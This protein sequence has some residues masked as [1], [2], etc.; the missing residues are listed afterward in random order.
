MAHRSLPYALAASLVF[1]F[2]GCSGGGCGGGPLTPIPG[3]FPL[4][5]RTENGASV[6]VTE[7]GLTFF[8][9]NAGALIGASSGD[10]PVFVCVPESTS[11]VSV[12]G[13]GVCDMIVCPGGPD[14][15]AN[16]PRC[17]VELDAK[18]AKLAL[19]S[20]APDRLLLHGDSNAPGGGLPLRIQ[21]LPIAYSCVGGL[22]EGEISVVANGNDPPACPGEPQ[23]FTPIDFAAEMSIGIQSGPGAAGYSQITIQQISLDKPSVEQA[24]VLDCGGGADDAIAQAVKGLLVG[25]LLG[26][27]EATVQDQIVSALALKPNPDV[28]PP[29]PPGSMPGDACCQYPSG[30]CVTRPLG[31]EGR[32]PLSSLLPAAPSSPE[33]NMGLDILLLA[34]G[35]GQNPATGAPWGQLD[36]ALGGATLGLYGG[37]L[38]QPNSACVEPVDIAP[39]TGIPIPDALFQNTAPDWP[40]GADGPHLGLALSEAFLD[41]ALTAVHNSGLLCLDVTAESLPDAALFLNTGALKLL[42]PAEGLSH[43][44]LQDEPASVAITLRPGAPAHAEIGQGGESDPLLALSLPALSIDLYAFSLDRYV[45]F[46][47]L[48][49]DVAIGVDLLSGPEGLTPALR[50]FALDNGNVS[51]LVWLRPGDVNA[52]SIAAGLV[53]LLQGPIESALAGVKLNLSALLSGLGISVIVPQ[54]GI[55]KVSQGEHDYLA[56]FASFE[57]V[58]P[59]PSGG[60]CAVAGAAPGGAPFD[61]PGRSAALWLGVLG[62]GLWLRRGG[63]RARSLAMVS[64][65]AVA[66]AGAGC[67]CGS[68]RETVTTT[69]TGPCATCEELT[70][71]LVGAYSSAVS[72]GSTLWVAGYLEKTITPDDNFYSWGDLVVGRHDGSS[73]TWEIVDGLPAGE[74]VD[75]SRHDPAGFRGGRVEP[76]DDVGTFTSIAE[77]PAGAPVIAYHDRTHRSL[78]VAR[79]V[80]EEWLV[81]TVDSPSGGEAGR[82]ARLLSS[83]GVL[84]IAYLFVEPGEDGK[85]RSGVRLATTTSAEP[86]AGDWAFEEVVSTPV[87]PPMNAPAGYPAVTG[88]HIAI[89]LAPGETRP[90]IVYRDGVRGN[91]VSAARKDPDPAW[92]ITVL[93]GEDAAGDDTG[94]VG[95]G[96]SLFVAGDTWHIA[97][98]SASDKS[99]RYLRVEGGAVLPPEV[100]DIGTRTAT[101]TFTGR[102]AVGA[103]TSIFVAQDGVVHIAYQDATSGT[104][105]HAAAK[106]GAGWAIT[107]LEQPGFGGFFPSLLPHDGALRI[108][109]FTRDRG[110]SLAGDVTVLVP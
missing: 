46:L 103:D 99:L 60:S 76:G 31:I 66:S 8:G 9:Q 101:E 43:L 45:R 86:E 106:K 67:Q 32:L 39:P 29:C 55:G 83:N 90:V 73:V 25:L 51:N 84:Q 50:T 10:G 100:V 91:L 56:L 53:P 98:G 5:Q 78:K 80:G 59:Q 97:C 20:A 62:V 11:Q 96:A 38:A 108:V 109:S 26:P 7:A 63:A 41:H 64:L 28:D 47:T 61:L 89:A 12:L 40:A 105:R 17:F 22:L 87:T 18:S 37:L 4:E 3:G 68:A 13:V 30:Q 36:P 104:L 54:E 92:K 102:H 58:P 85:P 34:G 77:G 95:L 35:Q 71:G 65:L 1:A 88:S 57:A 52:D 110:A 21:H 2:A 15:N 48:T 14:V 44:G 79:R 33:T 24:L 81:H 23:L 72:I 27:M 16:P 107:A 19:E 75:P 49:Y 94:D 93:D 42:I 6:R 82:Y 69:T 74:E 70:P